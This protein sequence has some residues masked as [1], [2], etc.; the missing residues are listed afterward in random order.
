MWGSGDGAPD[1][2]HNATHTHGQL[3][4]FRLNDNV[5]ALDTKEEDGRLTNRTNTAPS[6][7][8]SLLQRI[9]LA[10]SK[11][12]PRADE[13]D[14]ALRNMTADEAG[15]WILT[16]TPTSFQKM[17]AGNYSVGFERDEKQLKKNDGDPTKWTNPLEIR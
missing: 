6:G 17:M 5:S 15:N 14:T 11:P 2:P 12:V 9:G 7:P 1:D 8:R 4:S 13:A 10:G 3:V 16:R